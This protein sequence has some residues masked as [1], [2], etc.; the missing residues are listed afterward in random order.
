V[1]AVGY[2]HNSYLLLSFTQNYANKFN[3]DIR[4]EVY[5]DL[6]A[7]ANYLALSPLSGMDA[8]WSAYSSMIASV[9]ML[10]WYFALNG[11]NIL[12]LIARILRLMVRR[13]NL[14]ACIIALTFSFTP[15]GL[16]T[17]SWCRDTLPLARWT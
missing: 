13:S 5:N 1:G 11:I 2:G 15:T 8:L 12:L 6:N 7:Q 3:M 16:P 17:S 9:N 4:Y 14:L 10:N